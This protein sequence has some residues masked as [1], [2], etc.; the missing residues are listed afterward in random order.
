MGNYTIL[1]EFWAWFSE[2]LSYHSSYTSQCK[3]SL[4]NVC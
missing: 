1:Y 4:L 2:V 3:P